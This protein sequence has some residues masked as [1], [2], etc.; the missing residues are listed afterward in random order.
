MREPRFSPENRDRCKRLKCY[1]ET[2][3]QAKQSIS[4]CI[5][6]WCNRRRRHSATG[7]R[8][9]DQFEAGRN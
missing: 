4:K 2:L 5:E 8:S 7:Y 1:H 9:P 3:G 6:I